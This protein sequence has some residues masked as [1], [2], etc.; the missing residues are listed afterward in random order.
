MVTAVYLVAQY[1][2]YD[3]RRMEAVMLRASLSFLDW[4]LKSSV[5]MMFNCL[6][7]DA[8]AYSG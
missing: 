4:L 8:F 2:R 7:T 1:A 6:L 3:I 5:S